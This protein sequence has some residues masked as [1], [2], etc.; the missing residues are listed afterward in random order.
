[1]HL[2]L[3]MNDASVIR[4]PRLR[5]MPLV[6][7]DK[8]TRFGRRVGELVADFSE[9]SDT[10]SALQ[11][12]RITNAAQLQAIAERARAEYLA[13]SG[14][15]TLGHLIRVERRADN[16]VKALGIREPAQSHGKP[17]LRERLIARQ[18][19]EAREASSR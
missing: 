5:V 15:V 7:L 1:M 2:A 12:T 18:E 16:A 8:R 19:A 17:S 14:K 9:A 11:A 4:R 13:A 3:H 10:V 6:R